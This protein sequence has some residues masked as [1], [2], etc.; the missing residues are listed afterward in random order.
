MRRSAMIAGV[1][2]V[3]AGAVALGYFLRGPCPAPAGQGAPEPVRNPVP[4]SLVPAA[5]R[6][7]QEFQQ[8]AGTVQ[9]RLSVQVSSRITARRSRHNA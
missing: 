2:L 1:L 6:D 9:S 3:L 8:F 7:A 5:M 4:V